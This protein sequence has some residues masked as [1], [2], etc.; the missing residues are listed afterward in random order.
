MPAGQGRGA[1][2]SAMRGCKKQT[3][4]GRFR[5]ETVYGR[6]FYRLWCKVHEV[7]YGQLLHCAFPLTH[8]QQLQGSN[9]QLLTAACQLPSSARAKQLQRQ[10]ME[11]VTSHIVYEPKQNAYLPRLRPLPYACRQLLRPRPTFAHLEQERQ[12]PHAGGSRHR[13]RHTPC[14]TRHHEGARL[15]V[16]HHPPAALVQHHVGPQPRVE[17]TQH[18]G[19]GG[20]G[21]ARRGGRCG[22]EGRSTAVRPG[23]GGGVGGRVGAATAECRGEGGAG[24]GGGQGG[25]HWAHGAGV[26]GWRKGSMWVRGKI[27]RRSAMVYGGARAGGN[28]QWAWRRCRCQALKCPAAGAPAVRLLTDSCACSGPAMPPA[29]PASEVA[30]LTRAL[31]AML[32]CR[33]VGAADGRGWWLGCCPAAACCAHDIHVCYWCSYADE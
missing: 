24:E 3:Q 14:R 9:H 31:P 6:A 21:R 12:L 8:L 25:G 7:W 29:A 17:G 5:K 28:V 30:P 32:G 27:M 19:A 11:R 33:V 1:G 20:S 13:A 10:K 26:A 18:G 23:G 4:Q 15:C 2:R 22:G 16:V